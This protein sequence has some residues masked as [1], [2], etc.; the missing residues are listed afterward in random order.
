MQQSFENTNN[1]SHL[2][3]HYLNNNEFALMNNFKSTKSFPVDMDRLS[4][5]RL[6]PFELNHNSKNF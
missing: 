1:N 3:F 6:D 5:L 4:D 2:P